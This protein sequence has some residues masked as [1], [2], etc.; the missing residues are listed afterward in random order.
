MRR[1]FL[2]GLIPTD[3]TLDVDSTATPETGLIPSDP[4]FD[5]ST[6]SVF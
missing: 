5:A 4:A 1:R 3:P 2:K 6:P